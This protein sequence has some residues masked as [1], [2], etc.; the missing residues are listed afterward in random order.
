MFKSKHAMWTTDIKYIWKIM[1]YGLPDFT[2]E[3]KE[4]TLDNLKMI[5]TVLGYMI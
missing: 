1:H 3:N 4:L 5:E 2:I